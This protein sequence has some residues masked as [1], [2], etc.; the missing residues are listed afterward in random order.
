MRK[1]SIDSV[2]RHIYD[3]NY[4]AIEDAKTRGCPFVRYSFDKFEADAYADDFIS[5]GTTVSAK[6]KGLKASGIVTEKASKTFIDVSS[7][8]EK[9]GKA[10][11]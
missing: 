10:R 4:D 11:A 9:C 5:S 7:L 2:C 8:M 1:I 3:R 6:W